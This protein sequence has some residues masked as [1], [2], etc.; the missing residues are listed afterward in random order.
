M[1]VSKMSPLSILTAPI[2]LALFDPRVTAPLLVALL[3]YPEK[4]RELLPERL[5]PLITSQAV[6]RTLSVLLGL[7]ILRGV[8][9]KLSQWTANNWK[10][11][12]KF[13]KSQELILISGGTSGIGKL[14][15]EDFVKQGTKVIILDL[16]PP[17]TAL[18]KSSKLFDG[19][20]AN[21]M[22]HLVC[23]SISVM[24]RLPPRLLLQQHR[25]VRSMGIQLS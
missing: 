11:D 23:T 8:N 15:A 22:K 25:S 4:L 12:A 18:R 14:M 24:S 13:V 20:F 6:V 9:Q 16:N 2:R 7:G 21:E 1:A 5:H 17:K 3:Y 19:S 10:K